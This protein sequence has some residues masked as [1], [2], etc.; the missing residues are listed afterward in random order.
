[1]KILNDD[2]IPPQ[3]G[4]LLNE[5]SPKS[6]PDP[7]KCYHCS[8]P[9]RIKPVK[10]TWNNETRY[11]CCLGCNIASQLINLPALKAENE[12]DK[13]V[14]SR[15]GRERKVP[16][17]QLQENE[18]QNFFIRGVTCASCGPII[19][20]IINLQEG[21]VD[22]K[23]NL[24]S[25]R[26]HLSLDNR[27]SDL[28]Q[29]ARE[30]K[31]FGYTLIQKEKQE[32]SEYLTE[33]YLLRLGMIWFLSMNIMAFSLATYFG[34]MESFKDVFYWAT[35]IEA[36]FCTIIIFILGYPLLKS[37]VQKAANRQLSMES[38]ISLG[39]LTAYFYSLWAL[40]RGRSDIYFDTAS[41]IIA[42]VLLGK[43]LENAA[44]SK[45][46]QTIRKLLSLGAKSATVLRNGEEISVKAEEVAIDDTV[47]VKPGEIIPVDGE[48]TVGKSAVDESMLTGES[49]PV[50][51]SVGSKV[52]AA[53]VNQEGR[54]IFKATGI[55]ENTAL[56]R[57][58]ELIEKAQAEKTES[59]KLA[60]KLAAG[61][62]PLVL[63]IAVITGLIW[64]WAGAGNNIVLLN[65]ISVLVVACP[66]ALG[67]AT[68]MATYVCL[69]KAAS[70]GIILKDAGLIEETSKINAVV[71]DKTG[72]LTEG[73]MSVKEFKIINPAGLS[74][75]YI[76]KMAGSLEKY[77]EHPIGKSISKFAGE[78]NPEFLEVEDFLA[79]RG[80]GITGMINGHKVL[81]GTA[82]FL[83]EKGISTIS[84]AEIGPQGSAEKILFT[85]VYM[86][87]DNNFTGWFDISDKI[88][89][90]ARETI[91]QLKERNIEIYMLTGDN[92]QTAE[93][94]ARETGIENFYATQL[95]A[96]KIA[97]INKLQDNGKK[98]MMVGDGINDAPA[99]V[100]ADIGVAIANASDISREAADITLI[101][102]D[103]EALPKLFE[104]SS[105]ALKALKINL[106][107]A[108]SYNLIAIPLAMGGLLR[109]VAAAAAMAI[110]SLLIVNNSLRLR[111]KF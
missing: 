106:L 74:P 56:A 92:Y 83:E 111:R 104:L 47:I 70:L 101:T 13:M 23:V 84:Q 96:D 22:A 59:Q 54:F 78:Q 17:E 95:P 27:F 85:R 6:S 46:S 71:I 8:L 33:N 75:D 40:F 10:N 63:I 61:F 94:V 99:L 93:K 25:E 91:Q 80:M 64:H 73:K 88:K 52:Y 49:L 89:A 68:P 20:K 82:K 67:L 103:L 29:I 1:M 26:V 38:L 3:G 39:T 32:D 81:I 65:A 9:I 110:S 77:S 76:L 5:E 30:L 45:A 53:T 35:R 60:D 4:I 24:V 42:L 79:V 28:G 87:V 51:K 86:A 72:T 100:R 62:I 18:R 43:F 34:Q 37:A 57:I 107:W 102:S 31:K 12:L 19:E 108:F 66:C 7:S 90:N 50:E 44:K 48:I 21:V 2:N 98:V 15:L 14:R 69:D 58:V 109:P 105:K 97:F 41:M 55:G 16:T 11:F 36:F